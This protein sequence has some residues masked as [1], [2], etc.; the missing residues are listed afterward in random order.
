MRTRAR[1]MCGN[2]SLGD[3]IW[4]DAVVKIITTYNYKDIEKSNIP[5]LLYSAISSSFIDSKRKNGMTDKCVE[6]KYAEQEIVDGGFNVF[7]KFLIKD[8]VVFL[9]SINHKHRDIFLMYVFGMDK[10]E[11]SILLGESSENVRKI[12]F[13]V[14][15]KIK[16]IF[17]NERQ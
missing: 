14:R 12:I 15:N 16:H 4:H 17:K 5:G 6:L 10:S 7:K 1:V 8:V 3:D 11:I 13:R 2:N 9:E